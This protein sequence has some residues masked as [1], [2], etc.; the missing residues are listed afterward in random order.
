MS[1]QFL[2]ISFGF[3]LLWVAI[4]IIFSI[5]GFTCTQNPKAKC[6]NCVLAFIMATLAVLMMWGLWA[7]AYMHQ[8]NPLIAPVLEDGAK[9]AI[10]RR[11]VRGE[12]P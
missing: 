5:I 10:I 9:N 1:S 8:A 11:L 6:A 4:M 7:C 3:L 2:D 12:A